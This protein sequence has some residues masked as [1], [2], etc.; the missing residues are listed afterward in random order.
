[1]ALSACGGP[2]PPR[3]SPPDDAPAAAGTARAGTGYVGSQACRECH[4]SATDAWE[5][6]PHHEIFHEGAAPAFAGSKPRP[7]DQDGLRVV[8]TTLSPV[9]G[10]GKDRPARPALQ[11]ESQGVNGT[12]A[13]DAVIGGQRMEAYATKLSDGAWLLLPLYYQVEQRAFLGFH[14]GTCGVEA[15]GLRPSSVWQAYDRVWNHRCMACHVTGGVIGFDVDQETYDTHFLE[16]G[17]GCEACHGPG[18]AHIEAARAGRGTEAIVNPARMSPRESAQVCASCHALSLPWK[19]HWRKAPVYTPGEAYDQAFLTLLRPRDRGPLAALAHVDE[20]PA[21]GAMEYQGLEQSVCF[22]EGN[23]TC[24][25]CHDPHGNVPRVAPRDHCEEC[26]TQVARQGEEHSHHRSDRPGGACID[27]HMPATI[28][29]LGTRLANHA[30]DIPVPANNVD[31]GAPDACTLCHADRGAEWAAEQYQRLWGSPEGLRRRRIARAFAGNDPE[32]LRRLLRDGGESRLLRADAARALATKAG[33]GA[34]ADLVMALEPNNPLVVRRR[35]ADLLGLLGAPPSASFK[36]ARDRSKALSTAGVE[37]AL[38][39]IQQLQAPPSLRLSAAA[40]LARLGAGDG[41]EQLEA[42][43]ADP[44][45]DAGYRLHQILGK[46]YLLGG[47]LDEAATEYEKTLE[48]TPNYLAVIE[49]LGFIH[50]VNERFEQARDLWERGL[51]LDPANEDLKEKLHLVKDQILN[52]DAA[53]AASG[54]GT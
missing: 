10:E 31:F 41:I 8:P 25:T 2:E 3:P 6:G 39:Q 35:A 23:A 49:D 13:I 36:E 46:Y 44:V 12:F 30:I 50:F 1:M 45:L 15:L 19:S 21:L 16:P 48:I 24:T 5:S 22:L 38:R 51:T 53:A 40:A 14:Q 4:E 9:G 26:H 42:L 33:A 52:R 34:A 20:T 17:V 32:G 47:R 7:F 27:C 43:R 37:K 29:V 54:G 28:Q 18:S 11:V